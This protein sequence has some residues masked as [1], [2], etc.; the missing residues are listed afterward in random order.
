MKKKDARMQTSIRGQKGCM[1]AYGRVTVREEDKGQSV[2]ERD[3]R[4]D[5]TGRKGGLGL[6]G[7]LSDRCAG[8]RAGG[9]FVLSSFAGLSPPCVS[10]W[11]ERDRERVDGVE[12]RKEEAVERE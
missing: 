6:G 11:D 5:E 10:M 4:S 2:F 3:K 7:F 9:G 1:G 8:R 12:T